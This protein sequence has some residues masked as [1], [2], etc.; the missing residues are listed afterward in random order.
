MLVPEDRR[1][2]GS[3]YLV[4]ERTKRL[5]EPV[6]RDDVPLAPLARAVLDACRRFKSHDLARAL[7]T[8]AVQRGRVSPH[9]LRHELETGSKR[10]TAIPREVLKD[11]ATGARSVAEIDAMRVWERTGLP[12]PVWNAP[13]RNVDGEYIATPDAWFAEARL[14]WE[15]DSYEFHFQKDDYAKT[16]SRNA[17]YAAA[18]IVVMQTLPTRLRDTPEEV[19][20]ELEAAHAAAANRRERRV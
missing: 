19:A 20:K 16:L 11:V 8:E 13:L 15:I 4:V 17:R 7:I 2:H 5:P 3:D 14:A 6:V 10:G 12:S 1:L 9:W 18:G